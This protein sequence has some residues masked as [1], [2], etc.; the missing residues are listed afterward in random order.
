MS[1][2]QSA[3]ELIQAKSFANWM[4]A[5]LQKRGLSVSNLEN[6]LQDGLLLVALLEELTSKVRYFGVVLVG[7]SSFFFFFFFFFLSLSLVCFELTFFRWIR[8]WER[9]IRSP[10]FAFRR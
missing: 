5:S 1:S 6:D 8:N 9:S 10:F 4:N 7:A 3:W 2:A